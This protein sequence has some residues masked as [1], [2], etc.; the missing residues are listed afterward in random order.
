MRIVYLHQYFATPAMAGGTRSYEMGRRLVAS[1]HEVHLITSDRQARGGGWRETDEAG[2][3]VHWCATPYSNHMSYRQRLGAFFQFAWRAAKRAAALPADVVFASSTPLTVAL[4]GVWA[5]RRQSVPMV[6]EVRDLWPE[7]PIAVGA[8]RSRP[9][10]AAARRLERFAYENAAHVVALSPGMKAGVVAAGYPADRVTVIPNSCDL[11]M[12]RV[13]AEVGHAFR[14][15]Y[16][17]LQH[18]PLVV[19]GGTLNFLNGVDYLARL[20]AVVWQRNT[21]VRFLVVG[22]G[23]EEENVRKAAQSLG[24]LGKNFFMLPMM[25]KADMPAVLSAADLATSLFLDI[26][27]M[28]SNSANKLFDALA[29]GRPIAINHRGW[30]AELIEDT[31]CGLVLDPHDLASSASQLLAAL[32]DRSWCNAARA[33]AARTAEARFDRDKLAAKLEAVLLDAAGVP[34]RR[35]AA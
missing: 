32:G 12:F 7:M 2:I 9:V 1:G 35:M 5:A 21:D 29:A 16:D 6:F 23:H 17:W 8:I 19:Y 28:G 27:Q 10:I 18:R 14:R 31:G 13:G 15:R 34:I 4:P 11:Q 30:L 20:A 24:V 25:P 26:E 3:H 22:G 33:A